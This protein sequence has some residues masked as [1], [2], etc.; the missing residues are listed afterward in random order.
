M[1][2]TLFSVDT[3]L[4][5]V[6]Q[7]YFRNRMKIAIKQCLWLRFSLCIRPVKTQCRCECVWNADYWYEIMVIQQ[8]DLLGFVWC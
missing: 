4:V 2:Y 6:K 3:L 8:T 1:L 7:L 5:L